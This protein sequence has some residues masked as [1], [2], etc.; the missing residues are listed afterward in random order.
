[1]PRQNSTKPKTKNTKSCGKNSCELGFIVKDYIT[2]VMQALTVQLK[3]YNMRLIETKCL[4]TAVMFMYLFNGPGA[5]K[6]TQYCDVDTVAKRYQTEKETREDIMKGLRQELLKDEKGCERFLY[7]IMIT[8]GDFTKVD[9]TGK[10]TSPS[11]PGHVFVIEKYS[12]NNQKKYRLYQSYIDEYD[13]KGFWG[14]KKSIN[15][16]EGRITYFMD[17]LQ[18]LITTKIWTVDT[19]KF[20]KEMTNV[21]TTKYINANI[22]DACKLCFRKVSVSDC[23]QNLLE[24]VEQTLNN[25]PQDKPDEIYGDKSIYNTNS[26]PL[27]NQQMKTYMESLKDILIHS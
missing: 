24:F 10:E 6:D 21:D 26:K 25:I 12:D 22:N 3:E 11:F 17:E 18:K 14:L 1:M 16:D 4:N 13:F 19:V 23:V 20:W 15:F 5:I 27:T 8:H 9:Q 2:P 7:Y